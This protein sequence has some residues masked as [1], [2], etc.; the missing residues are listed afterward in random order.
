M[1]VIPL[2]QG[3][4][5]VVCDCHYDLVKDYKWHYNCGYVRDRYGKKIHRIITNA[6]S[7][8]VVDHING[9]TLDNQCTNLRICTQTQNNAN[10]K[11]NRT[12]TT[13][14]KGVSFDKYGNRK[15]KWRASIHHDGK[16]LHLGR[17]FTK[18]LAA[19]SYNTAAKK[20]KGEYAKLN[21]VNI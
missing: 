15:N 10:R 14:L 2:T 21:E 18:E 1:A 16:R 19:I 4:E 9:N 7:G 8:F 20:L 12:S 5:A 3:K 13:G 11:I 6:P 17:F